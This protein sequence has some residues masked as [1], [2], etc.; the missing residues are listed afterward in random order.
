MNLE[1]NNSRPAGADTAKVPGAASMKLSQP[2]VVIPE[3][4]LIV[5]Q[6]RNLV[7]FPGMILPV[8]IGREASVAAAQAAV[9]AERPIGLVLQRQPDIEAPKREDLHDVG[10]VAQIVRYI[11]T[12]DGAHHV[13][14]Q[15]EG[16]FRVLELLEGYPFPVARIERLPAQEEAGQ[17]M[18]ARLHQLRERAVEALSLLPQTPPELV[19][20]LQSFTSAGQLADMIAGFMDLK[21]PEKQ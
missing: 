2:V 14:A 7:L 3:D 12:P 9:K 11:T 8:T 17:A 5:V 21:A 18:E 19:Q 13:V 4:A 15:G 20:S 10:T 6:V 16:R 1:G